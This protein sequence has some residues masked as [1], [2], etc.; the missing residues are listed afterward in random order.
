MYKIFHLNECDKADL[1]HGRGWIIRLVNPD[2]GTDK[3]D[4]HLNILNAGGRRGKLH[5]HSHS[6]NVYIVKR[7]KAELVVEGDRQIIQENDVV[8]IPAKLRH[9]L[10]NT[11]D[12]S[13]EVFEIYAPAGDKFDFVL[14]E[15]T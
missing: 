3:L 1:E 2:L 6:D 14:D 12:Q 5:H 7:G 10:S 8:F 4:L 13:F 15:K 11:G 9:S